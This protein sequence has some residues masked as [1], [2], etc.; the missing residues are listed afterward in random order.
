VAPVKIG[1]KHPDPVVE[2]ISLA[3]VEPPDID[4]HVEERLKPAIEAKKLSALQLET[5]TYAGQLHEKILP[6]GFRA[7]FLTGKSPF[8]FLPLSHCLRLYNFHGLS[9]RR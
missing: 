7:G 5:I 3:S 2:T 6:G 4:Y 8:F 9:R 1:Y